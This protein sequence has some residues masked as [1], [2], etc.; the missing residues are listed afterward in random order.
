MDTTN[1]IM[2]PGCDEERKKWK[3]SE[4]LADDE[5]R[6]RWDKVRKYFFL[7]ESTYDMTNR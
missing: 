7:L 2:I 6:L 5:V 3:F 1:V 4:L